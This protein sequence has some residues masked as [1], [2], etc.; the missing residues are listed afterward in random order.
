M[1]G[2][3]DTAFLG[4]F[5]RVLLPSVRISYLILPKGVRAEYEKIKK[6]YNQT[7]SKA[8]QIK[9]FDESGREIAL[10]PGQTFVTAVP[11]YGSVEY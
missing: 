1:N 6:F 7:A 10:A 3:A 2:G 9:F 11:A 8:E 5:S 4:S